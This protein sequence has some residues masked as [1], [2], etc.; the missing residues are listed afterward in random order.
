MS[1]EAWEN[2]FKP[3]VR[4]AGRAF[5]SQRKVTV[6]QLSDTEVQ[7]YV[8]GSKPFKVVFKSP[9]V[10]SNL[11]TVE[12]N[13]PQSAKGQFCKHIWA[14]LLVTAKQKPDFL[15]GKTE[16]EKATVEVQEKTPPSS[17]SKSKPASASASYAEKQAAFKQKQSDYRKAQ[18]QKQKQ[19]LKDIKNKE[20][21]IVIDDS[22]PVPVEAALKYF[23]ENGFEL[24]EQMNRVAIAA[25]KKQLARVF[26]PD[27][28]GSHE[29]SL[30]LNRQAEILMKFAK[31]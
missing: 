5:V 2:F 26:H 25:A 14:A 29:E 22:Y 31:S 1:V 3:E 6:S 10:D 18:Y 28:G 21:G 9:R 7:S 11:V 24:R 20:R 30:E 12:C 13:C 15:E 19:R 4:S 16:I 27:L 17:T 23:S 8:R